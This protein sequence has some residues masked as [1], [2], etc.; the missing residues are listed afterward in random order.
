[1]LQLSPQFDS[2]DFFLPKEILPPQKDARFLSHSSADLAAPPHIFETEESSYKM[3]L[4]RH[5]EQI[6]TILNHLDELPFEPVEEM[7]DKI[8]GLRNGQVIIQRDFDRL[9]TELEEA[10][11]QIA[12]LQKIQMGHDVEVVLA[13]VRISTLEM[14]IEDIQNNFQENINICSSIHDPGCHQETSMKGV[15]GLIHWF[16]RT[17]SVFSR[18]NCTEDYK[19]KFSTGT[20]TEEV[21]SLWNSF[22]QPI[23]IVTPPN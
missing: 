19:V 15:V 22:A 20:L 23:G 6:E 18:S 10:R 7:E 16:E 17:E 1:V 11:T 5:E 14:I 3:P 8:R 12:G 4:K 9:E 13:H 2:R 21:L